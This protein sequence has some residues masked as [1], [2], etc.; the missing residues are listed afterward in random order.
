MKGPMELWCNTAQPAPYKAQR[1]IYLTPTN[2]VLVKS[3]YEIVLAEPSSI[4]SG[5]A[6][7]FRMWER[8]V[9]NTAI[10]KRNGD[11]DEQ[12]NIHKA[13]KRTQ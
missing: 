2:E 1:V 10:A 11:Q 9:R 7:Q 6:A 5:R 12:R 3:L 4:I 8:D 13:E